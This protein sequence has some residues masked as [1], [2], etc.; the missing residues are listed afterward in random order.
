MDV[1]LP[2]IDGLEATRRLLGASV[3][4]R[5]PAAVDV[6]R[7]GRRVLRR[8]VA[9]QPPT[10]RRRRSGRI[11]WR[12]C[13]PAAEPRRRCVAPIVRDRHRAPRRLH[14]V[15]DVVVGDAR[16]GPDRYDQSQDVVLAPPAH[17]DGVVEVAGRLG[18]AEVRRRLDAR[19]EAPRGGGRRRPRADPCRRLVATR[20]AR[21]AGRPD[22]GSWAGNT[23]RVISR[24][25]SSAAFSRD[26]HPGQR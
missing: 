22:R 25:A 4:H 20:E 12:R 26:E 3:R 10:S 7:G 17:E 23:P 13:G 14:P 19:R 24:S 1:N 6:R 9:V 11:G 21:A 8:R 2:G 5:G 16:R 18:S 15:A